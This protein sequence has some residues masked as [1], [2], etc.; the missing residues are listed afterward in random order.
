MIEVKNG[1]EHVSLNTNNDNGKIYV[2]HKLTNVN[3]CQCSGKYGR[4]PW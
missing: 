2:K 4:T 3:F 1:K